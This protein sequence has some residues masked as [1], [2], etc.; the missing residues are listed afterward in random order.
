M[1]VLQ[2]NKAYYPTEGGVEKVVRNVAEGLREDID[3]SV[4]ACQWSGEEYQKHY[5]VN[6]VP[7]AKAKT[8]GV[9]FSMPVAPEFFR[10]LRSS[11][12]DIFHF[13]LPFPL[14]E[15][16]YFYGNPKGKIVVWWHSD[17]IKQ[18]RLKYLFN[19]V[20]LK[21]LDKADRILVAT[22]RHI[23]SSEI[24]P[25]F[26]EKCEVCHYGIDI[27]KFKMTND[28]KTVVIEKRNIYGENI[29]LFVGRLVYY[30]GI[31]YLIEAFRDIEGILLI[32][33]EGPLESN[34]KKLVGDL[35]L[36]KRIHFLKGVSDEDLVSYYYL[37]DVFCLP[38]CENSEGFGLVQ[39][40]AMTCGKPVVNTNLPTGVP[41]VSLDG[42]TGITVPP[43][44]PSALSSA[45]NKL[46]NDNELRIKLGN[47]AANRVKDEFTVEQMNAKLMQIYKQLLS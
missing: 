1:R 30:K 26:Q 4:L 47:N 40:E 23:S 6:D 42:I 5:F 33:G 13:H 16:A 44:N 11:K 24:L 27:S 45:I 39:L 22:P 25:Q 17:I 34:L 43:K 46:L 18:K 19:A 2:V 32:V 31:Q 9:L 38:S 35:K 20:T 37:C 7:I 12:A 41:Y 36:N 15:L 10:F 21:F 28:V 3:I 8:L 14:S 29:V